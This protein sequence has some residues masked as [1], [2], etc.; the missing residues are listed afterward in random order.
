MNAIRLNSQNASPSVMAYFDDITRT[1]QASGKHPN[2]QSAINRLV[3]DNLRFVVWVAADYLNC[4]LPL[5]DLIAEGNVGLVKAAHRFDASRGVKFCSYAVHWVRQA[6]REALTDT[7]STVRLPAN[8][9]QAGMRLFISS[10]DCPAF[11]YE[12]EGATF[13]DYLPDSGP[14][15]DEVAEDHEFSE[16]V[17]DRLDR[18]PEKEANV[19]EQWFGIGGDAPMTLEQIGDRMGVTRERVRQIRD[20][21]LETMRQREQR[22]RHAAV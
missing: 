14:L 13:L 3:T 2:S 22:R 4:G 18:L 12:P 16:I 19:I 20:R 6:I 21:G 7:V 11:D 10:L 17:R 8:Q 15:P 9:V 1:A 5:E